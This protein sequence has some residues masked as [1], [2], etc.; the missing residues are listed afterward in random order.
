[1]RTIIIAITVIALSSLNW[2]ALYSALTGPSTGS[3]G[4]LF[5]IAVLSGAIVG[6]KIGWDVYDLYNHETER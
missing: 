1:M 3:I 6:G 2:W 4:R 5:T